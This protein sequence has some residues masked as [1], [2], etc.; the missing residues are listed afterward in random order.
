[1]DYSERR[2]YLGY[3]DSHGIGWRYVVDEAQGGTLSLNEMECRLGNQYV[4]Q[5]RY[6]RSSR[7]S[8]EIS[9]LIVVSAPGLKPILVNVLP[10]FEPIRCNH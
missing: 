1:M 8:S 2:E 10:S 4:L 9:L 5:S 6:A 3:Y 7:Y